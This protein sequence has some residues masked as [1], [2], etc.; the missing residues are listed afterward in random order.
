MMIDRRLAIKT[1]A[2]GV[3]GLASI[4]PSSLLKDGPH[5]ATAQTPIHAYPVPPSLMLHS[6]HGT[7]T[8]DIN[9]FLPVLIR[10]LIR[11][12]YQG[13]TYCQWLA[14]IMGNQPPP[15]KPIMVSIDDLTMAKGSPAFST[16]GAMHDLFAANNFP[17]TFA[18]V[19]RLDLPQDPERWAIVRR[20]VEEGSVELASHTNQHIN[21]NNRDGSPRS[22]LAPTAYNQ[23][24]ACSALHISDTTGVAVRTLITP[25]GSGF[26]RSTQTIHPAVA[27]QCQKVGIKVVVGIPDGRQP[28]LCE[29]VRDSNAVV[30][31]GRTKPPTDNQTANGA[32][33]ELNLWYEHD[34]APY[35]I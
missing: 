11:D 12:G 10:H 22:D 29:V 24:I 27:E 4:F 23:Q 7:N 20:W 35:L 2:V 19:N 18:V 21:F 26:E 31:L 33:Y 13:I 9:G 16:F 25:Y 3:V 6:K 8:D 34:Y 14:L 5:P 17:V 15:V 1:M 32:K 28:I 30:Y